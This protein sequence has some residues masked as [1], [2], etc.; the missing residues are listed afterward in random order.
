M[1]MYIT[2]MKHKTVA[3]HN[4]NLIM[5]FNNLAYVFG[6]LSQWVRLSYFCSKHNKYITTVPKG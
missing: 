5:E 6:P 4:T 1:N 2:K 3:N